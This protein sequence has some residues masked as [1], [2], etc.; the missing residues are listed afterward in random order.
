[1]RGIKNRFVRVKRRRARYRNRR[2]EPM[3]QPANDL[4]KKRGRRKNGPAVAQSRPSP[5]K[6][7]T[8]RPDR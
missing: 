8:A 1:M 4:K 6:Y 7:T 5:A 3:E 2:R